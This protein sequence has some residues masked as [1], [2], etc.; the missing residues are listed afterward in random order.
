VLGLFGCGGGGG[1]GEGWNGGRGG[2]FWVSEKEEEDGEGG[3]RRAAAGRWRGQ[4]GAASSLAPSPTSLARRPA[5]AVRRSRATRSRASMWMGSNATRVLP[6]RRHWAGGGNGKKGADEE[7]GSAAFAGASPPP[8]GATNS[9]DANSARSANSASRNWR[10]IVMCWCAAVLKDACVR[11]K[12][13][14]CGAGERWP[15]FWRAFWCGVSRALSP[16][17]ATGA[18]RRPRALADP[19]GSPVERGNQTTLVT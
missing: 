5:H 8:L 18:S 6:R 13:I 10:A 7:R 9:P 17:R 14:V 4:R 15:R 3:R 19:P 16:Q 11:A 12:R 1:G 2:S